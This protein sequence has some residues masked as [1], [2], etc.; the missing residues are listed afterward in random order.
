MQRQRASL[1]V[2]A[3]RFYLFHPKDCA[4]AAGELDP[5]DDAFLQGLVV[6]LHLGADGPRAIEVTDVLDDADRAD[7]EGPPFVFPLR[8][9][10]GKL[11]ATDRVAGIKDYDWDVEPH[12]AIDKGCYRASWYLLRKGA[13]DRRNINWLLHL[14][15]VEKLDGITPWPEFPNEEQ[16]ART[17]APPRLRTA[18]RVRHAKF[19]EGDV[20][21]E[22][23]GKLTVDF[24]GTKRTIAKQFLEVV[25]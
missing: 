18:R 13:I 23:E 3:A 17:P 24:A 15:R 11:F 9:K 16:T 6:G 4:E 10:R 22:A 19:G 21:D 8:V 12:V 14:E 5:P 25:E 1:N 2:D 20:V 7:V